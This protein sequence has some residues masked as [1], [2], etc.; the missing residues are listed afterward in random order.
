M[1][2]IIALLAGMLTLLSP[3]TLPVIPFVFASVRGKKGQLMALLAG[4]VMMFT[5]VALLVSIAG[6]WVASITAAGRWFALAF[7]ALTAL[8]LLSTRVAQF[9]GAPLI[10][11]GN[12]VNDSSHRHRGLIAALLA[13]MAIGLLWSPCA[14][15]VLGAL[16]SLAA[17]GKEPVSV[18][19]LIAAY[20]SGCA[21]MLALLGVA[22]HGLMM[23]LRPGMAIMARLRQIS[24][25]LMLASVVLIASGTQNVLQS[26][27]AFAQNLEQRLS[28][29]L[30]VQQPRVQLQ[31][32][33]EP[34]I[35]NRMPSLAGGTHWFN[36]SPVNNASLKGKV[37]LVDFWTYDCINCQHSLPHV[38]DWANKYQTDGLVVLGVHTPEYPWERDPDAVAKAIAK[39]RLPYPV[40][41]DN[42]YAIWNNFGNRYWPAHYIFDA[43]G[44]LRY[45]AFGE[46]DYAKQE[47]VIQQLLKETRA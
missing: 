38:R 25:G 23:R 27:P 15:P 35:T 37:V 43:S 10:S 5:A 21:L 32:V 1:S 18:G 29:H 26:A 22:G 2:L 42:N 19:L 31:P 3:C 7:L 34:Q 44:K 12:R 47:Q 46:G 6:H 11:L 39:W 40:V 13:G 14:G 36:G 30:S 17:V 8:T 24:G 4:M 41:A 45:T 16:L 33:V 20:G 9:I 28:R